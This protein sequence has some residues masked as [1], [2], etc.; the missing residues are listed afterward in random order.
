[1]GSIACGIAPNNRMI[2]RC[3]PPAR[4]GRWLAHQLVC[5]LLWTSDVRYY[6]VF[7]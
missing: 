2:Q 3:R 7:D 6:E 1:M 5:H 4:I